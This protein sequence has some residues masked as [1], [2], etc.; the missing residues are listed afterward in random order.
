L[1]S[2]DD[3]IEL[4]RRMNETLEAM[5]RAIFRSWFVDFDA[6][7][8]KAEGRQLFGMDAGTA[9]LFPDSFQDSPLG[10]IPTGWKVSPIGDVVKAVGGST[11]STEEQTFWNGDIGFCTPK[12]MASLQAPILLKT[13]RRITQSGLQ[14]ISSGIL[15]QGTVLLSSRAPIGYLAV[16]EIPVAVNQGIIALICD[17][18]LPNLYVLHW[19]RECMDTIVANANG[20]TFLEISKTNFRPIPVIVPPG[21]VLYKFM[22]MLSPLYQQVVNNVTQ[23]R[24][25]DAIRDALLPK[26][27]SGEIRLKGTEAQVEVKL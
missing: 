27:I 5:A 23:S 18:E 22:G 6:V 16:T 15:S 25:L 21:R 3:K 12:D 10:K 13:E 4:N 9:A 17:G 1:G 24:T 2:L 19:C 8:A 26:L 11:P 14:Q 20:T 7:R